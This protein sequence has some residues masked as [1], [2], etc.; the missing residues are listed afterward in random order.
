MEPLHRKL[1]L[2][3]ISMALFFAQACTTLTVAPTATSTIAT[4]VATEIPL[5]QQVTLTFISF[6]EE[7]HT[8]V[9]AISAQTPVLAGSDNPNVKAFNRAVAELIQHEIEY[10]RKNVLAQMPMQAIGSGSS[11]DAQ[12]VLISQKD[13]IWS[14]KFDFFRLC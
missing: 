5:S 2:V 11:F 14:F 8:P 7:G 4:A 13:G 1:G 6:K 9:Y 3:L 10:F 12:Y